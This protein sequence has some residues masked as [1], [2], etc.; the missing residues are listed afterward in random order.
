MDTFPHSPRDFR[1]ELLRLCC[2]DSVKVIPSHR[3]R[4]RLTCSQRF[5]L[6]LRGL[7]DVYDKVE[8]LTNN[9]MG[10]WSKGQRFL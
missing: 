2:K 7:A 3:G 1:G 5:Q 9:Q 4:I 10:E 8:E 6:Y